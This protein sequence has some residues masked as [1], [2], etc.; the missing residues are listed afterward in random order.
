MTEADWVIQV[1]KKLTINVLAHRFNTKVE[2]L[3]QKTGSE[4]KQQKPQSGLPRGTDF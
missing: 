1:E 4:H 2:S 3:A